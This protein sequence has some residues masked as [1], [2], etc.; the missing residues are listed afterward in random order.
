MIRFLPIVILLL[1]CPMASAEIKVTFERN[2]KGAATGEFRFA[3]VPGLSDTDAGQEATIEVID[4]KPDW[5]CDPK[6]LIDGGGPANPDD[7]W[8]S[9][10][11]GQNTNSGRIRIDLGSAKAIALVNTFSWNSGARA[12]QVYTLYGADGMAAAFSPTP[13]KGV[14]P[15]TV[16]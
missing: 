6:Q 2:Q 14:D 10:R 7:A 11:F 5:G 1:I 12:P 4:G 16:G 9:F 3:N 8:R 15:A 13:R